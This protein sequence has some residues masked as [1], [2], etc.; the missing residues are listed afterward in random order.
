[1]KTHL[2]WPVATL[3]WAAQTAADV[4]VY[5][6]VNASL[7]YTEEGENNSY[8]EVVSNASRLGFKGSETVNDYLTAIY[9]L[10]AEYGVDDGDP[11]GEQVFKARNTF[12][13]IEGGFGQLVMG[14]MDTPLKIIQSRVDVFNDMAGDIKNV[15]TNSDNRAD[16]AVLYT[17]PDSLGPFVA[18]VGFIASEEDGVDNGVSVAAGVRLGGGRFGFGYDQDVEAETV[19]IFRLAGEWD[20]GLLSLA[21]L[22]E[23]QDPGDTALNDGSGWVVSSRIPVGEHWKIGLQYGE[24]DIVEENTE[25]YGA[26]LDYVFTDNL[27]AY[28]FHL[29]E[30]S[31]QIIDNSYTGIGMV[32]KF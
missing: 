28:G 18:K 20:F 24:S 1:M 14:K 30:E 5:G 12:V 32:L 29:Q 13:G 15:I 27:S 6:K 23:D 2:I 26:K 9:Q 11:G 3:L 22:W 10:E 4:E 7:Q 31:D 19:E 16:N 25:T 21:A 17:T 8:V